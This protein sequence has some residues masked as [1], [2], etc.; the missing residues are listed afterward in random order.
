MVPTPDKADIPLALNVVI[1]VN[2]PAAA[3]F[4]YP[5]TV[6]SPADTLELVLESDAAPVVD[7]APDTVILPA[8][9]RLEEARKKSSVVLVTELSVI[10]VS[11]LSVIL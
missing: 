4:K 3:K 8:P 6:L 2:E 7:K 9:D 11:P 5:N 10:L 1:L